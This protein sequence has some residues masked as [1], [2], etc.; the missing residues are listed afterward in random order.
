MAKKRADLGS[1]CIRA[2]APEMNN[3]YFSD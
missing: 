1:R 3:I 2:Y